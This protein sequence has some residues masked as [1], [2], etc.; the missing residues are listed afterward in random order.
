[1]D[2]EIFAAQGAWR[3]NVKLDVCR[4]E[5]YATRAGTT[6]RYALYS[7]DRMWD[8]MTDCVRFGITVESDG[9]A[10]FDVSAKIPLT[11]RSVTGDGAEPA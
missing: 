1:M 11:S 9:G 2:A 5:G 3:S 10:T 4:W 6:N 8:R 7:W